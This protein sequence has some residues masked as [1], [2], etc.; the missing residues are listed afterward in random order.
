MY[1]GKMA[2]SLAILGKTKDILNCKALLLPSYYAEVWGNIHEQFTNKK[3]NAK[4]DNKINKSSG[5]QR[6][7]SCK[8]WTVEIS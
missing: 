3:Y 8:D 5:I 6:M 2:Q 4:M 1:I 7:N